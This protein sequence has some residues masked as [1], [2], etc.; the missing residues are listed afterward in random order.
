MTLTPQQEEEFILSHKKMVW[1]IV[2]RFK[3]RHAGTANLSNQDLFQECMLPLVAH[4]KNA[5]SERELNHSIPVRDMVNAMC[6]FVL[7][8][9]AV[10][11]PKRTSSFKKTIQSAPASVSIDE[12]DFVWAPS[13]AEN[14]NF[15]IDYEQ[16]KQTL[17]PSAANILHLRESGMT[18]R[19][20]AQTLN[21]SDAAVTQS[22]KR[23][24][25]KYNK[26]AS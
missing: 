9:Q 10:S 2:W 11:Y 22:L 26:Y 1:Y 19:E 8:N 18:N 25:E 7:R 12:M 14:V 23:T 13:S 5:K 24:L 16:F 21:I 17:S 4:M 20:I 3:S 6:R 15:A